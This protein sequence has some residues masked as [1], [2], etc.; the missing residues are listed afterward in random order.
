MK[1]QEILSAV[2]ANETPGSLKL[3][4]KNLATHVALFRELLASNSF[5]PLQ[6][7]R[8]TKVAQTK[9]KVAKQNKVAPFIS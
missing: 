5:G 3:R 4:T 7:Q 8:T 9:L 2:C 6:V 1:L